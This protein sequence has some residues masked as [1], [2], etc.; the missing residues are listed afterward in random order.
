[1]ELDRF[2]DG[3]YECLTYRKKDC[4]I[5]EIAEND[6]RISNVELTKDN[7]DILTPTVHM[8]VSFGPNF[9]GTMTA[10]DPRHPFS[11]SL[12]TLAVF[13]VREKKPGDPKEQ[14]VGEPSNTSVSFLCSNF[15]FKIFQ[16]LFLVQGT[17]DEALEEISKKN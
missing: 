5:M 13:G 2:V 15:M 11:K 4:V 7:I 1:M 12:F 6:K 10:T 14:P 3:H 17:I 9:Y 8:N 16:Y